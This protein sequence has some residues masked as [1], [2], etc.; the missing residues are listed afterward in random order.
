MY[1]E[2]AGINARGQVA[3]NSG[4]QAFLWDGGALVELGSL[5]EGG[6]AAASDMNDRGEIV[7]TARAAS[8]ASHAFLWK[9]GAMHDLGSLRGDYSAAAAIS[10]SG[11]VAGWATTASGEQHAVLWRRAARARSKVV[12]ATDR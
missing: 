7:G 1:T 6:F 12:A 8:G 4:P 10:D 9:D 2:P 3:G 11:D 5:V